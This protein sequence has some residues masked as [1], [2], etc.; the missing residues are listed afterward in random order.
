MKNRRTWA[1]FI[2]LF[3]CYQQGFGQQ[4]YEFGYW[5]SVK[6]VID[7][8]T[9]KH[10][11]A[12]GL[13]SPVFSKIDLD[14]DGTEDLFAFDRTHNKIFTFL[15]KAENGQRQWQYAPQYEYLFP[16]DLSGWVL[17]RDYDQDGHRDLFT[18]TSLGI[19]V[20]RNTTP[21]NGKLAFTEAEPYIKFNNTINLQVASMPAIVDMDNDGDLDILTYDFSTLST[22]EYYKNL[23]KEENLPAATL[24]YTQEKTNW[25][26]LKK[27]EHLCNGYVFNGSCRTTGT[28]HNDGVTLLALDLDGDGDKDLLLG[29]DGCPDLVKVNN[30][31]TPTQEAMS[32]SDMQVRFPA[33][34]TPASFNLYPSAYYEDVD[35]DQKPDL[36]VTPFAESNTTDEIDF[37]ASSWLYKNNGTA[38][39]PDFTFQQNNF[40]QADMVDVG[41]NSVPAL[42]DVDAD[43]DVDLLVGN[44]QGTIWFFRNVGTRTKPVFEKESADY[45][46]LSVSGFRD[47]KP[48]FADINSDGKLDLILTVTTGTTGAIKYILNTA[49]TNQAMN[50]PVAQIKTLPV[51]MSVGSAPTFYDLDKDGKLD[52]ILA[53][54][55]SNTATSGILQFYRHTG[56]AANPVYTLVNDAWGSIGTEFTRRNAFPLL[57]D[58]NQDQDPELL[59]GDDTGEL[60]VFNNVV[61]HL[62]DSLV[63]VADL[64]LNPNTN[65]Y[66]KSKL[67][68][69]IS[70]AAADLDGDQK[71]EIIAGSRGGG[72]YFLTQQ[73]RG[74]LGTDDPVAAPVSLTIFPN[75][76]VTSWVTIQSPE[77][78]KFSIYSI[79][80]QQIIFNPDLNKIHQ[81]NVADL[82]PGMYL[83]HVTTT[84][85]RQ[86]SYKLIIPR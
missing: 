40:L 42:A 29:G 61:Q 77:E 73:G 52:L 6:I 75:P 25:G 3:C 17:L 60:R 68:G 24:K 48:Q 8:D 33:N 27:C 21:T 66:E 58:L 62:N 31:G 11:G 7:S 23:Q 67:G 2:F 37:R 43:G 38:T 49:G 36:L 32:G 34:T 45:L 79:T 12:G 56:T 76:A 4:Q 83:V 50:F 13:N 55:T 18:Q 10:P 26:N 39:T 16:A 86:A 65:A 20:Y 41:E 22:L 78:I 35:F 81:V 1:L 69:A 63:A 72:L 71:P 15:A 51:T 64:F 82:A 9:I 57:A 80:G 53:S 70:L 84:D 59:L 28:L 54:T 46:N 14:Q 47:I 44:R 74:V 30:S 85:A 19:K 5:N